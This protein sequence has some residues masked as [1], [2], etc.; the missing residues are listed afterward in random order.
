MNKTNW[1]SI[2]V[3]IANLFLVFLGV[4]IQ[5]LVLPDLLKLNAIDPSR[6][7]NHFYIILGIVCF[8]IIYLSNA[9]TNIKAINLGLYFIAFPLLLMAFF[10]INNTL[11]K[12]GSY[13]GYALN[14]VEAHQ[15]SYRVGIDSYKWK[16]WIDVPEDKALQVDS[17]WFRV[18]KGL[19]GF[20]VLHSAPEIK[21]KQNCR[22]ADS[23]ADDMDSKNRFEY[24][25]KLAKNRCFTEALSQYKLCINEH[26]E[27]HNYDYLYHIGLMH[28][29]MEEYQ[30]ALYYFHL[31]GKHYSQPDQGLSADNTTLLKELADKAFNDASN[32]QAE[33]INLA[34][35]AYDQNIFKADLQSKM[36]FCIRK[37]G[38]GKVLKE[39]G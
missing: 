8:L 33:D 19:L 39:K 7:I 13:Q 6:I 29:V 4:Y 22:M 16:Y 38:L 23:I 31:S 1:K 9:R 20:E 10:K 30:D 18:D 12:E 3:T 24:A 36:T 11:A 21:E 32:L 26:S 28:F 34:L 2:L 37:L 14:R 27:E 35:E 15:G 25:H 5:Y 17:I